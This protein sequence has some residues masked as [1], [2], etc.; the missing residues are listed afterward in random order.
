MLISGKSKKEAVLSFDFSCQYS[1]L[2]TEDKTTSSKRSHATRMAP[3]VNLSLVLTALK[4]I[5]LCLRLR[6][7]S[8]T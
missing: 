8:W 7:T 4:L 6:I 3:C 2:V 1:S 5:G